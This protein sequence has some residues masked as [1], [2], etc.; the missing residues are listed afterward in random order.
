MKKQ[1]LSFVV[2]VTA[3]GFGNAAFVLQ[4]SAEAPDC[5]AVSDQ[6]RLIT[7][8]D[9]N[10][11]I[12]LG[13]NI[14]LDKTIVIKGGHSITIDLAG[15]NI[16][17]GGDSTAFQLRYG[18]LAIDG[19]GIIEG[20]SIDTG[21][22]HATIRIYGSTEVQDS[23]YSSLIIGE[24]VILINNNDAA[25]GIDANGAGAFHG[26]D[27][28][29]KGKAVGKY[30]IRVAT[31]VAGRDD[32]PNITI[33]D[34][35]EIDAETGIETDAPG[36]AIRAEGWA[37]WSIGKAKITG[38]TGIALRAGRFYLNGPTVTATGP[39]EAYIHHYSIDKTGDTYCEAEIC[40]KLPGSGAALQI[41]EAQT[42]TKGGLNDIEIYANGG[43]FESK[44]GYA[45]SEYKEREENPNPAILTDTIKTFEIVDGDFIAF[46]AATPEEIDF[47]KN[48]ARYTMVMA[49]DDFLW[50][51]GDGRMCADGS[52]SV[53]SYDEDWLRTHFE[54]HPFAK[55]DGLDAIYANVPWIERLL[56]DYV[57]FS[58]PYDQYD[59]D[60][61]ENVALDIY[62]ESK[63]MEYEDIKF[64]NLY[65][66]ALYR[67]EKDDEE[68][69]S[70]PFSGTTINSLRD[71]YPGGQDGMLTGG[72]S[73]PYTI[74]ADT[75]DYPLTFTMRM[76]EGLPTVEEGH[77][78]TYAV[79]D[80]H[81]TS[82]GTAEESETC[83]VFELPVTL[84]SDGTEYTF[85][86]TKFSAFVLTYNDEV[87]PPEPTPEPIPEP[88]PEQPA[89]EPSSDEP[90]ISVPNTGRSVRGVTQATSTP[91]TAATVGVVS[92]AA[93][94]LAG[95]KIRK[96][97]HNKFLT[98]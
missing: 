4:T 69:T 60:D 3:V 90:D 2:A 16:T 32:I 67:F 82:G 22:S 48:Y 66:L 98:K 97:L 94:I 5:S 62:A 9:A 80:L 38:D 26:I 18:K 30:G 74:I 31:D 1:I 65:D 52:A 71:V 11:N 56:V 44:H 61:A 75:G 87:T 53:K 96:I 88:T 93:V 35:A 39:D 68:L 37:N 13:S 12:T 17:R 45:I 89:I 95:L 63:G 15:H 58:G 20:N 27:V 81:C 47:L 6:T 14:N 50:H 21:E 57:H 7:C 86:T 78:R 42:S 54:V 79:L 59:F 83:E 23:S 92:L 25:I 73:K 41:Q 36:Q 49:T 64:T 40:E 10:E 34:G 33:A 46:T 43:T 19:N 28:V 76:P 51:Y 29:F 77:T 24:N 72:T 84:S 70:D 8:I 55:I 91:V 85:T